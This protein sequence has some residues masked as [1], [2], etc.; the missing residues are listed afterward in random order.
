[1]L[2]APESA[3]KPLQLVRLLQTLAEKDAAQFNAR[4]RELAYLGSVLVTG[5]VV[6][7]TALSPAE[8]RNAAL[9]TCN[10][11]LELLNSHG[12]SARVDREPGLVR[13]FLVGFN[14]LS[15]MPDRVAQSFVRCLS[16]L[17]DANSEPLHEWLV[18][19]AEVSVADL[20]DAVRKGDFAAA[21]EAVTALC[22]VFEPRACQAAAPLLDEIPR[23]AAGR[24]ES[25]KWI[26][27]VAAFTAAATLLEG[28][29]AKRGRRS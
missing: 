21:R 4:G 19:Q 8:A 1:L 5:V 27:S 28:L 23:L 20:I 22:F 10:L 12:E 26:D 18:E 2:L 7:G 24:G 9:A 15:A 14:A 29:P 25:A 6:E 3:S 13:L 16:A 17:H 11:G